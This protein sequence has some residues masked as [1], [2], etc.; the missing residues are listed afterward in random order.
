MTD[1]PKRVFRV[2]ITLT[3]DRKHKGWVVPRAKTFDL[4]PK[5]SY[6]D[7]CDIIIDGIPAKARLTILFRLFYRRKEEMDLAEYLDDITIGNN[8]EI[9][10]QL[11][12]NNDDF[13]EFSSSNSS[14]EISALNEKFL[15][16]RQSSEDMK[17][18]LIEINND[19]SE[20]IKNQNNVID[21]L[22]KD[23]A[24]LSRYIGDLE[25]KNNIL[26]KR[27]KYLSQ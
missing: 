9:D 11:L 6:E 26:E 14:D 4:I 1:I 23:N 15:Q 3:K 17:N 13:L 16:Y 10:M 18:Y 19:L 7:G 20:K 22:K 8:A 5:L 2:P 21:D 27:I 12:L 25:E 24:D